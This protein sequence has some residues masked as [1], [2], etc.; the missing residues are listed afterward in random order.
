M[1]LEKSIVQRRIDLMAEEGVVRLVHS[2]FQGLANTS[3]LQEFVP[4]AH[5]GVD[6]DIH[7]IR[8]NN[9]AVVLCTGATWPRD[10]KIPGRSA[11][12]VHFAMDYLQVSLLR[13]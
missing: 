1:K 8:A 13:S 2:V 10:L 5:V 3:V 9:D 4:N 7:E 6:T 12:G 11:D